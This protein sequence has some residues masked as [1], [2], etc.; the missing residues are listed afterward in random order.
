MLWSD[1]QNTADRLAAGGTEGDW[2][3]AVSRSYYGAFHY[4]RTLFL[5]HG[6]DVGRGGQSHSSLSSGLMNCGLPLVDSFG[7]RL[8]R[9]RTDRTKADYDF[10]RPVGQA[11]AK[12]VVRDGR[13]LPTDFQAMLA[14]VPA[15][16]IVAGARRYLQ[17]IGRIP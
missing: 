7:R 8:D 17:S 12:G 10:S 4:F 15:A 11:F 16:S 3:S 1:F 6:L 13:A 2:R 9:L 14:A 5:T